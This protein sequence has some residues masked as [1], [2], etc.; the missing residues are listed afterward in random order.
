MFCCDD[1]CLCGVFK[2]TQQD[3]DDAIGKKLYFG[4]VMGK[5]SCVYVLLDKED[6]KLI[7]DNFI[8]VEGM[9]QVGY[10]PLQH[11]DNGDD[12]D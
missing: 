3:I 5:H 8:V 11:I 6:I 10:N 4:E 2:A 9:R 12:E 7:S 1:G